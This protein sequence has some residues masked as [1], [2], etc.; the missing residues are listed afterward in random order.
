MVRIAMRILSTARVTACVR[1]YNDILRFLP[2]MQ[3]V[4]GIP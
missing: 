4:R 1:E 3:H 2:R